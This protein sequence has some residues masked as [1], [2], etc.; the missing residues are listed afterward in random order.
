MLES[1][2][3]LGLS[4]KHQRRKNANQNEQSIRSGGWALQEW[5]WRVWG[6]RRWIAL[7]FS[8]KIGF[9]LSYYRL[10]R[11]GAKE[12]DKTLEGGK[13]EPCTQG[14]KKK[15]SSARGS[16]NSSKQKERAHERRAKRG[17]GGKEL[18]EAH[19]GNEREQ[20]EERYKLSGKD[21]RRGEKLEL[22]K[23]AAM[24]EFARIDGTLKTT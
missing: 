13:G 7:P 11:S 14:R 12:K 3:C 19:R 23:N 8:E 24:P 1:R 15:K 16:A 6:G 4:S 18:R 2:C 21:A 10:Q 22:M 9:E 17:R 5:G 20:Q